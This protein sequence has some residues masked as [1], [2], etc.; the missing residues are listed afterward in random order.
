MR[1]GLEASGFSQWWEEMEEELG[2]ERWVGDPGRIRKAAPRKQ[3]TDGHDAGLLHELLAENRF[4]RIW[5]PDKATGDLRQMLMHR[6]KLVATRTAISNQLQAMAMNR[7]LQKKHALW[8]QEGRQ[9]L[10]LLE[11]P[12]WASRRRNELLALRE[13]WDEE[14]AELDQVVRGE[15]QR[16]P[17][18][19]YLIEHQAG[20]G[21]VTAL[22]VVLTLGPVER[23]AS[24]R[25]V[26]SYVG[27]IPAEY[28]SGARQRLGHLSKEGNAFLHC[29][30]R[31]GDVGGV[32]CDAGS[33]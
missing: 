8:A 31:I 27:L 18:A 15:A 1:V 9:Q 29:E 16:H 30:T 5:V 17:E 7:G 13:R 32:Y 19:R 21:P 33:D 4:S 23:F 6:H 24:A 10:K 20:V 26:A 28:S 22:A 11:L 25:K 14:I 2:I 12:P 3:K